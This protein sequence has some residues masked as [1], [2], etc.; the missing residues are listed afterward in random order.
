FLDLIEL[1]AIDHLQRVLLPVHD[2]L[3][4]GG[5][6]LR[7]AH[8]HGAGAEILPCQ[9]VDFERRHAQ[10]EAA[11]II[12]LLD[13]LVRAQVASPAV[14]RANDAESGLLRDL[15]EKLPPHWTVV[16][17]FEMIDVPDEVGIGLN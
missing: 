6:Q 15:V 3:L 7:N 9:L 17:G 13:E 2:A 12:E 1:L 11:Q 8:R 4:K 10:L 16:D 5:E 14:P